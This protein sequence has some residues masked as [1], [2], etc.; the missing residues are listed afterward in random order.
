MYAEWSCTFYSA[1]VTP[2]E[3][4][5]LFA[6]LCFLG[7]QSCAGK[8]AGL[9]KK[10]CR[11]LEQEVQ[12]GS[13]PLELS[14]SPVGP[15]SE[16]A[17]CVKSFQVKRP[18]RAYRLNTRRN[19]SRKT[20][21]Y[22]ILTLNHAYPDYDFSQLRAHHFDKEPSV[23]AVEEAIDSYLLEVSRV[24]IVVLISWHAWYFL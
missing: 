13:S 11:S 14:R 20:L 2:A 24:N 21:I 18:L 23:N 1:C 19:C 7:S 8:L 12:A 4:V 9:D 3:S 10:L 15:L 6:V 17:R 16:A 22:L 5:F